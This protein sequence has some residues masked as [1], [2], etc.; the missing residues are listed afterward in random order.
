M[1]RHCVF[2]GVLVGGF[3]IFVSGLGALP[4]AYIEQLG[5][6]HID[7]T[8]GVIRAKGTA[9]P[10]ESLDGKPEARSKALADAEAIARQHLLTASKA[11]RIDTATTIGKVMAQSSTIRN[12][13]MAM[14]AQAKIVSQKYLSDG[15]T[16]EVTVQMSLYG[17]LAQLVLPQEIKQV[18]SVKPVV[19]KEKVPVPPVDTAVSNYPVRSNVY[20]GLVIDARGLG[21]HA[22]MS[23]KIV[24][25]NGREVYGSAFVSREFAV[26]HGMSGYIKDFSLA[27]ADSRVKSNPLVVK[28]L[29]VKQPGGSNIVISNTDA[30]KLLGASQHLSFLKKCRVL[31]VLD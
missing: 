16:V 1:K 14:V 21:A 20:T 18:Q 11:V 22:V 4:H 26:Q 7:W 31:I 13:M 12:G 24:D 29:R 19:K 28:G 3:L 5:A 23:P 9:A 6:D 27:K 10:Q 30:A 2:F 15:G 25:E 17:G 8:L